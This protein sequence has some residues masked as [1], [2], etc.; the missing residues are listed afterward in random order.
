MRLRRNITP[1]EK[2]HMAVLERFWESY[3]SETWTT[4]VS[5]AVESALDLAANEFHLTAAEAKVGRHREA[6]ERIALLRLEEELE[7]LKAVIEA[8]GHD[9]A[10][11]WTT[12][13]ARDY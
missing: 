11:L 3:G 6:V 8:I 1:E 10:L 4:A 5:A 12:R 2:A 13:I 7:N 9:A